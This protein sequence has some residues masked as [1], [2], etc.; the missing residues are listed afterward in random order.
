[1]TSLKDGD[2]QHSSVFDQ[3]PEEDIEP[4]QTSEINP[5]LES[6]NYNTYNIRM[7]ECNCI[8]SSCRI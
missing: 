2:L 7:V 8:E 1:M 5:N 4:N 6:N 3:S